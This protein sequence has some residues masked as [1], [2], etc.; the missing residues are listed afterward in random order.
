MRLE[1][2]CA[3][4]FAEYGLSKDWVESV[5]YDSLRFWPLRHGIKPLGEG[6][7]IFRSVQPQ[8]QEIVILRGKGIVKDDEIIHP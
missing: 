7:S 5:G 6:D 2:G 3:S 8:R 4:S 1:S